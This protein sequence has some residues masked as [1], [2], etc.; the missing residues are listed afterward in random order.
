M[1]TYLHNLRRRRGKRLAAQYALPSDDRIAVIGL[2]RF[3]GSLANELMRRGWDVLGV[4]TDPRRIQHF[5]DQLT[6]AV[7]ADCT[8]PQP[9][10]QLGIHEFTHVVVGI[11]TG[12]EASILVT[13]NLLEFQ[14]PNI[15]AKAISRQHAQILER[16]GAHHVVLPE[17]EMGERVA[18]LVTGRLLDFIQFDDDYALAK[19]VTPQAAT[20]VPLGE[21]RVRSA[22]GVTVVGIKRPGQDFTYATAETVV[23]RGDVII[24]T[25]RTQN[26]ERFA[27]MS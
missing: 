11:G 21:S 4:D 2:G 8:D 23:E 9:A 18:H 6:H 13:S 22:Y 12:I 24:I 7:V 16:I 20:G 17:H 25:G 27:A 5:S 10:R 3:G 14:V 26:V 19:T 1:S 15:W